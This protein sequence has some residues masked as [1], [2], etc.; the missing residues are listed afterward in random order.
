MA[1]WSLGGRDERGGEG[2]GCVYCKYICI[3][4]VSRGGLRL[5]V[6]KGILGSFDRR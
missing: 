4:C 2:R 5:S 6:G 1:S 3:L